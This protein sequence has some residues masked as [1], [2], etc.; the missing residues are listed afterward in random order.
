MISYVNIAPFCFQKFPV[1]LE[2]VEVSSQ[3]RESYK[4]Q[5]VVLAIDIS[6]RITLLRGVLDDVIRF[7]KQQAY[8]I[9]M[10]VAQENDD[11]VSFT[12]ICDRKTTF[13]AV[14]GDCK[15][16]E[17]NNPKRPFLFARSDINVG[18]DSKSSLLELMRSFK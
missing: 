11:D 5:C 18:L 14:T 7:M 1:E 17:P 9:L 10:G 3:R 6:W 13:Q 15:L 16:G 4:L 12:E 2:V 8:M